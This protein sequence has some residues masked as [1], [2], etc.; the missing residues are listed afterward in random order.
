MEMHTDN[1]SSRDLH[2]KP[3]LALS[4]VFVVGLKMLGFILSNL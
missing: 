1:A 4:F 3:L 2:V